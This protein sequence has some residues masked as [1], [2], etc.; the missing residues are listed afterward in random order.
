MIKKISTECE[1]CYREFDNLHRVGCDDNVI[2]ICRECY[3]DRIKQQMRDYGEVDLELLTEDGELFVTSDSDDGFRIVVTKSKHNINNR[4]V[5]VW[6]EFDG[7]VWWGIMYVGHPVR[8]KRTKK[9][10]AQRTE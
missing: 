3:D 4:R 9:P 1:L 2:N 7:F 5:D 8:C 10:T 6:F